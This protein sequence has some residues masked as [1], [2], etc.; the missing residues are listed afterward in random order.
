MQINARK[1]NRNRNRND[2]NKTKR[3]ETKRSTKW[4]EQ[5][6]TATVTA[7]KVR[8]SNK[9]WELND[10]ITANTNTIFDSIYRAISWPTEPCSPL[11]SHSVS[12]ALCD[13]LWKSCRTGLQCFEP[14]TTNLSYYHKG[15][16]GDPTKLKHAPITRLSTTNNT[17]KRWIKKI[18][19]NRPREEWKKNAA[20]QWYETSQTN[21]FGPIN[22]VCVCTLHKRKKEGEI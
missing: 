20:A 3:N 16:K 21:G 4:M 15:K 11:E 7:Q 5:H 9:E 6:S 18:I 12:S 2:A 17:S 14:N 13:D 19:N 8:V 22:G 1:R 10:V